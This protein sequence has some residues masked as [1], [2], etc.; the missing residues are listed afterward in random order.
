MFNLTGRVSFEKLCMNASK[1]KLYTVYTLL[2]LCLPQMRTG[3]GTRSCDLTAVYRYNVWKVHE[4][5]TTVLKAY[6]SF[7]YSNLLHYLALSPDIDKDWTHILFFVFGV[8]RFGISISWT[9]R[10]IKKN[11][12]IR[13][14]LFNNGLWIVVEDHSMFFFIKNLTSWERSLPNRPFFEK[15]RWISHTKQLNYNITFHCVGDGTIETLINIYMGIHEQLF[16]KTF[17]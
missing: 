12:A 2:R 3:G 15:S 16:K 11:E 14:W 4:C 8:C 9:K 6:L 1:H 7:S 17:G 13:S 5:A 10:T